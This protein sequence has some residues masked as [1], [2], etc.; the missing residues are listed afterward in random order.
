MKKI[1]LLFCLV[2][3]QSKA[4]SVYFPLSSTDPAILTNYMGTNVNMPNGFNASTGTVATLVG[5]T[6]LSTIASGNIDNALGLKASLITVISSNFIVGKS[7]TNNYGVSC[8]LDMSATLAEAAVVGNSQLD[9][10]MVGFRTNSVSLP[11]AIGGVTDNSYLGLSSLKVP[12]G[13]I[14][15]IVDASSGIGNAATVLVGTG[16]I[17]Y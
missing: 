17:S 1:I 2:V 12:V 7:F 5:I 3:L 14:V 11:T 9:L 16:Q 8:T 13:G 15:N 10:R 6:T 4:A